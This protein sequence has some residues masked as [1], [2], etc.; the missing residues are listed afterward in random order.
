M[1]YL[2]ILDLKGT[3][4]YECLVPG[5]TSKSITG[6]L[7]Y[8]IYI[9]VDY[10]IPKGTTEVLCW[11]ASGMWYPF[12]NGYGVNDKSRKLMRTYQIPVP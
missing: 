8:I 12:V 5:C 2:L 10:V 9:Y 7:K 1:W 6:L 11:G 3:P 4:F